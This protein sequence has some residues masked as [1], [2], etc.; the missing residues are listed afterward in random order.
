VAAQGSDP[1]P[2]NGARGVRAD[3]GEN[4]PS[5]PRRQAPLPGTV[6]AWK[7][8]AAKQPALAFRLCNLAELYRQD[9]RYG[10]AEPLYRRTLAILEKEQPAQSPALA[11]SLKIRGELFFRSGVTSPVAKERSQ[12]AMRPGVERTRLG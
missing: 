4:R 9:G 8:L 1:Q 2:Q 6:H 5:N 11:R 7:P 10:K 3:V 12:E